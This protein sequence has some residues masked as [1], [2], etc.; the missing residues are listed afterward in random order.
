MYILTSY[1]SW[2]VF[3]CTT[4][5]KIAAKGL[6]PHLP[7]PLN[8]AHQIPKLCDKAK[9][10]VNCYFAFFQK[11]GHLLF[12]EPDKFIS[13][14]KKSTGFLSMDFSNIMHNKKVGRSLSDCKKRFK[15]S[16]KDCV[17]KKTR[18]F[19]AKQHKVCAHS[20]LLL[21]SKNLST[22][23]NGTRITKV[24]FEKIPHSHEK[25]HTL[26]LRVHQSWKVIVLNHM[27]LFALKIFPVRENDDH[28]PK[29]VVRGRCCW[30]GMSGENATPK[31]H[32]RTRSGPRSDVETLKFPNNWKSKDSLH[33]ECS[34]TNLGSRKK[35]KYEMFI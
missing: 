7:S 33:S 11:Q 25:V 10:F 9:T 35:E 29:E 26:F 6:L 13:D 3:W 27:F 28:T 1:T 24:M 14:N 20:N 2:I 32:V 30:R 16:H 19:S 34:A 17:C 15:I 23:N 18:S 8:F 31:S 21:S 5:G 4:S 22:G 12:P